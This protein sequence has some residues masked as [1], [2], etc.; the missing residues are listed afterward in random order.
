MLLISQLREATHSATQLLAIDLEKKIEIRIAQVYETLKRYPDSA[1]E[2]ET[3]ILH[4]LDFSPY[5]QRIMIKNFMPGNATKPAFFQVIIK[6]KTDTGVFLL[7]LE[8]YGCEYHND[9]RY[10]GKIVSK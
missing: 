4:K 5:P 6:E 8:Y 9:P 2:F 10:K 7:P 1:H 3:L